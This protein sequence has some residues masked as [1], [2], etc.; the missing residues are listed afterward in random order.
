MPS[1]LATTLFATYAAA[2]LTTSL[3]LPGAANA[4]PT[5]VGSV[6]EQ[7]GDRTTLSLAFQTGAT[8]TPDYYRSAP[9]T[10]TFGGTTYI[11]Y[12][13][14]AADPIGES[15]NSITVSL[16]CS[17]ANAKAAPTCTMSTK[18]A[19]AVISAL[20]ASITTQPQATPVE[21]QEYCTGSESL[22]TQ[23]TL[24]LSGESQYYVN[25][26]PLIITAGTDKLAS[27]A[28]TPT[29]SS[30][31]VTTSASAR[32]GSGTASGS[33]P[34]STG[35]AS[36]GPAPQTTNAAAPVRSMAPALAGLGA[37]AAAFFL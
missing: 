34:S 32:S 25:N 23:E 9:D 33:G 7:N 4:D 11:A 13:A 20:C 8:Q 1:I 26:F 22:T 28:A 17:R 27:A 24:T 35:A 15:D 16:A 3:W 19:D 36:S 2:Q 29:A 14:T 30:A 37:A 21:G 6:I 18:G 5:F 31:S 12:E 10:V